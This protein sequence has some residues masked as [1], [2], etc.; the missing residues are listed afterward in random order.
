MRPI[1]PMASRARPRSGR[2]RCHAAT[3]SST[4]SVVTAASVPP[5]RP[6]NISGSNILTPN[7]RCRTF[8]CHG[9]HRAPDRPGIP[10]Q[11]AAALYDALVD[12]DL[13]A[14]ADLARPR[15]RAA[16]PRHPRARRRAPRPRRAP[17]LHHGHGRRRPTT[18]EALEVLDVLV[19]TDLA[20][21]RLPGHRGPGRAP[22]RQLD[23][24]PPAHPA[25]AGSS[26][27][28]CT[29]STACRRRLLDAS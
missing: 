11:V 23:D 25:T 29:T 5:S 21:R 10:R 6:P 8:R 24:P 9:H 16:R 4:R 22:A 1:V 27:S 2:S 14:A 12:G 13:A 18:G 20:R 17:R 7:L 15:R 28:T 3:I 19:G 26:R